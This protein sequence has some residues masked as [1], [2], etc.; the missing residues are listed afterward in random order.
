MCRKKVQGYLA[1]KK[2]GNSLIG[3]CQDREIRYLDH[4]FISLISLC[5]EKRY[6]GTSLKRK[7]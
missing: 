2:R 6:R 3:L 7:R 1:Q 5:V 4:T